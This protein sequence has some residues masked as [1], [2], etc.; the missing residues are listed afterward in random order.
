MI[1]EIFAT[2][3]NTINRHPKLITRLL[4]AVFILAVFGMTQLTMQ[5]SADTYLDKDSAKGI[6]YK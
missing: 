3:A 6:L 4:L 2:I 5:T 1:Q